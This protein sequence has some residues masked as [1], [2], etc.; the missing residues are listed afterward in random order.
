M[1]AKFKLGPEHT[2]K[3]D[4]PMAHT[5]SREKGNKQ[6]KPAVLSKLA[7]Y[8]WSVGDFHKGS[9]GSGSGSVP[10]GLRK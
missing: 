10:E 3:D 8:R 2:K 6:E 5:I 1:V 9:S 4:G 7:S